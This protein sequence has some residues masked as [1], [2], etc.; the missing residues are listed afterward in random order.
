[1]TVYPVCDEYFDL[2]C[3]GNCYPSIYF[4]YCIDG[5]YDI[6]N[7]RYIETG[8]KHKGCICGGICYEVEI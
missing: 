6:T 7:D 1:M 8:C 2:D 4:Y 3:R 5:S